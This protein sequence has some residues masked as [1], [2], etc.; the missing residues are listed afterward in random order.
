MP[1]GM[2]V[3]T[4]RVNTGN[5]R[6]SYDPFTPSATASTGAAVGAPF[7]GLANVL[8]T[9]FMD[10]G[11]PDSVSG[12]L[13]QLPL[14]SNALY[15]YVL[16]KSTTNP[17][18]VAN[19]GLVY[20]T[21][22][23]FT[24]VSGAIADGLTGTANSLAGYMMINTTDLTTITATILNNGGNGS[25]V[26]ICIGGYVK[27]ATAITST[28][29]GDSLVGGATAFTPVRVASGTAP[30]FV[31]YATAQTNLSGAVADVVVNIVPIL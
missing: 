30:T 24:V 12:T 31:K 8:G 28:A 5:V 6:T 20:Y 1:F 17:A 4:A 2:P 13:T 21:D 9:T 25:G 26:W 7:G 23:T 29:V 3:A 27:A 22:N 11:G 16:Y 19:P 14:L 15:K 18:L 10:Q